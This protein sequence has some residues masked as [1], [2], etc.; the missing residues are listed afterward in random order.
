MGLFT[1]TKIVNK[2]HKKSREL[3]PTT[4]LDFCRC[5]TPEV[6][7]RKLTP[8]PSFGMMCRLKKTATPKQNNSFL[9]ENY[10]YKNIINFLQLA[11]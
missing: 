1:V 7:E 9:Q 3:A 10:K 5:L 4:F 8:Q 2:L 6:V 11:F